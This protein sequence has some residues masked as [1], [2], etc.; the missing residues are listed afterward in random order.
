MFAKNNLLS[1]SSDSSSSDEEQFK[2]TKFIKKYKDD[3]ALR[4]YEREVDYLP[5]LK[6]AL[7]MLFEKSRLKTLD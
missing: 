1:V 7:S 2:A 5:Y 4:F 6:N 3:Y